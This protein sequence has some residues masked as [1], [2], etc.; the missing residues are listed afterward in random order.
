VQREPVS[1]SSI[2]SVGYDEATE[3]LEIEFHN[4]RIYQFFGVPPQMAVALRAAPSHGAYF[5]K[6]LRNSQYRFTVV[7]DA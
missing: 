1:S 5:N 2:A 6:Y 4:G 3:T 7:R